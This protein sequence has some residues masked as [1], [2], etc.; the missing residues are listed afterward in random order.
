MS[1]DPTPEEAMDMMKSLPGFILYMT[2]ESV[3]FNG[4]ELSTRLQYGLAIMT[5]MPLTPLYS[6]QQS[7]LALIS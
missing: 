5:A 4:E 2:L 6:V 7:M 1:K 3:G